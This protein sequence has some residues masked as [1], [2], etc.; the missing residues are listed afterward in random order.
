MS[1]TLWT[2]EEEQTLR[3]MHQAPWPSILKAIPGRSQKSIAKKLHNMGLKRRSERVT[4]CIKGYESRVL[5]MLRDRVPAAV[6][7]RKLNLNAR[8]IYELAHKHEIDL[9]P[10]I[11]ANA[12]KRRKRGNPANFA[13]GRYAKPDL[14][15][16]PDIVVILQK[17]GN[18][19]FSKGDGFI[20]NGIRVT[21]ADL[22]KE[23]ERR[24]F[25]A[26]RARGVLKEQRAA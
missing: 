3:D 5:T 16:M 8:D 4:N 25:I 12:R 23:V 24:G 20:F 1:G 21:R 2:P 6:V 11:A 19:V 14:K 26:C 17:R 9:K 22:K 13:M 15:E 7:A 10:N 18:V